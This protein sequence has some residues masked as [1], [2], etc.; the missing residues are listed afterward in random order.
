MNRSHPVRISAGD[1]P[2]AKAQV[3]IVDLKLGRLPR[4]CLVTGAPTDNLVNRRLYA[5]PAWAWW[6]LLAGL[7][8]VVIVRAVVGDDVRAQL[9]IAPQI[10]AARQRKLRVA[11]ALVGVALLVTVLA[12]ALE[13]PVLL[14]VV[15]GLLAAAFGLAVAAKAALPSV[16]YGVRRQTMWLTRI[17]Q[18]AA[19]EID[20]W[21]ATWT[22]HRL[23]NSATSVRAPRRSAAS[24]QT[25]SPV[26]RA[27]QGPANWPA[28]PNR[29]SS[30]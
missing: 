14:V 21:M 16:S 19:A 15:V 17:H 5:A 29:R 25:P 8:P 11:G 24:S 1:E 4:R 10:M 28:N 22:P 18:D 20:Q 12:S 9:P 7:L 2:M 23:T 13:L 6:F 26:A 3:A 30:T 27:E